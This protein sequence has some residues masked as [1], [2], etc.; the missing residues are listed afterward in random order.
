MGY[1]LFY[2][3]CLALFAYLTFPFDALRGRLIT[4]FDRMIAAGRHASGIASSKPGMQLEIG[5][6]KGYWLSGVEVRK[7]KLI[8]PGERKS[9]GGLAG[10]SKPAADEPAPEPSIITIDRAHARV[11]LLSLIAGHVKIDFAAEAL[12]GE[13][14]GTI[15]Y[16]TDSGDVELALSKL[17]LGEVQPLKALLGGLPVLGT[18][19]GELELT[20]KEGK[21]SKADGKMELR[22]EK[23]TLGDGKSTLQGVALPAAQLGDITISATAKDGT[24]KIADLSAAGRDVELQGEGR[25]KVREPWHRSQADI[26]LKFRFTDVYRDRDDATRGLLGK[27]GTRGAPAIEFDPRMKRAKQEDGFYAWHIHGPLGDLQFDPGGNT[28]NSTKPT[29]ARSR[30]TG[31]APGQRTAPGGKSRADDSGGDE[32]SPPSGDGTRPFTPR[33]PISRDHPPD[34]PAEA[35]AGPAPPPEPAPAAPEPQQPPATPPPQ[36]SPPPEAPPPP[37]AE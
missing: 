37:P 31:K 8:M 30:N 9:A 27:P 21:F 35:P 10:F 12:G 11:R 16:G 17:Q 4:E 22:F 15:P 13:V 26:Y 7:A 6:L 18:L 36:D 29:P 32:P 14:S 34:G 28:A 23:V 24:I 1:P 3:F 33:P 20:P 19:G 2:L 5:E 25:I